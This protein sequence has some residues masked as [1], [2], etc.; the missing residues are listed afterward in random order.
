MTIERVEIYP[1]NL[2]LGPGESERSLATVAYGKQA[3]HPLC[4]RRYQEKLHV[5][6]LVA[7]QVAEGREGATMRTCHN[8]QWA[9]D[10]RRHTWARVVKR[11]F[12]P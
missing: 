5:Y 10:S 1:P 12:A 8:C 6:N 4:T 11:V 3:P 9:T 2:N 7:N